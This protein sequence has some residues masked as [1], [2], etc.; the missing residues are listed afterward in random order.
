MMRRDRNAAC[1]RARM[2][3]GFGVAD[4]TAGLWGGRSRSDVG[5]GVREGDLMRT[6]ATLT[7]ALASLGA[8]GCGT[9]GDFRRI[10]ISADL[11]SADLA[12]FSSQAQSFGANSAQIE[13]YSTGLPWWPLVWRNH[14]TS[15]APDSQRRPQFHVE[16]DWGLALWAV[17]TNSTANFDHE[18]RNTGWS[19]G[20]GLLLGAVANSTGEAVRDGERVPTSNFRLLWGLFQ[21]QNTAAG[22]SWRLL[23]IPFGG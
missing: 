22:S 16:D 8:A 14:K 3:T 10:D 13:E 20:Q 18:G 21:V 1:V 7:L 12:H 9:S 2:E 6:L 19:S 17:T 4:A 23:W 11:T 15:S 5:H